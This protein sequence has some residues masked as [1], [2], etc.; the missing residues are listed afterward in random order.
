MTLDTAAP[1]FPYSRFPFTA[2]RVVKVYGPG[3]CH[4]R[5]VSAQPLSYEG[6]DLLADAL[7]YSDPSSCK[8]GGY[9]HSVEDLG[10]YWFADGDRLLT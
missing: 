4:K 1:R 2:F 8:D 10:G 7:G 5:V 3:L 9:F 6:A